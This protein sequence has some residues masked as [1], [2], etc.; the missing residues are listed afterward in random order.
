DDGGRLWLDEVGAPITASAA[1]A[2]ERLVVPTGKGVVALD[3]RDGRELWRFDAP[4]GANAAPAIAGR[5]VYAALRSFGVKAFDLAT[6]AEVMTRKLAPAGALLAD[7][8][9]VVCGTE[10]GSLVRLD[11]TTGRDVWRLDLGAPPNMG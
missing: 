4:Y 2:A 10:D 3:V 5:R 11:P 7:G 1:L 6:G 9:L 8:D